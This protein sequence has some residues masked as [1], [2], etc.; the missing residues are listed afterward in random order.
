MSNSSSEH[1]EWFVLLNDVENDEDDAILE[2]ES[3]Y[4]ERIDVSFSEGEILPFEDF[5]LPIDFYLYEYS[6]RGEMTDHLSLDDIDGVVLSQKAK[7]IFTQIGVGN[8]QYFP[9][10][11]IDEYSNAEEVYWANLR[12]KKADFKTETYKGY[13]I[14]NFH[15]LVDCIDHEKSDCEYFMSSVVETCIFY[16]SRVAKS[17][18]DIVWA[19]F[20][21]KG[22][23]KE[24]KRR[25]QQ[26]RVL[27]QISKRACLLGSLLS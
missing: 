24:G 21:W 25:A 1:S 19:C 8:V 4:L 22:R 15:D 18:L 11:L 14:A 17:F 5:M 3:E 23:E 2:G 9:L 6:L 20:N 27:L 16:P 7:D 12:D 26:K 13:F 10:K